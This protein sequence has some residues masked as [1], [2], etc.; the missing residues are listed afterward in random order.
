M[1]KE[2]GKHTREGGGLKLDPGK[3]VME[4]VVG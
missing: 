3:G 2:K 1:F 4:R